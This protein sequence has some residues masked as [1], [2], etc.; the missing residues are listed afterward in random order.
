MASKD[1][2]LSCKYVGAGK[3]VCPDASYDAFINRYTPKLRLEPE[4][5]ASETS[6]YVFCEADVVSVTATKADILNA[7][8]EDEKNRGVPAAFEAPSGVYSKT[9]IWMQTRGLNTV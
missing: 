5:A 7:V 2:R 8:T 4:I 1:M 6:W 3:G 9:V